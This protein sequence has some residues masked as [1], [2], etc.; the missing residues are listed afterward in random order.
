MHWYALLTLLAEFANSVCGLTVTIDLATILNAFV[1]TAK[2]WWVPLGTAAM[3]L[4]LVVNALVSTLMISRIWYVY[5]QSTSTVENAGGRLSWVASV[6]L[7][8]AIALFIAQLIYLVLYKLEHD[9][10]ALVAGPV[11]IIYV[12]IAVLRYTQTLTKVS[13]FAGTQLHRN[14]GTRWDEPVLRAPRRVYLCAQLPRVR[15]TSTAQ[16]FCDT[17]D[18]YVGIY[19]TMGYEQPGKGSP[20]WSAAQRNGNYAGQRPSSITQPTQDWKVCLSLLFVANI[21]LTLTSLDACLRPSNSR[22][23]ADGLEGYLGT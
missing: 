19:G 9:A 6:L 7:E 8:S 2:D 11:T 13:T 15:V 14:Y 3:T 17:Y 5:R 20:T 21:W 18:G 22:R 4:S 1:R 10:F 23:C 16:G 12:R